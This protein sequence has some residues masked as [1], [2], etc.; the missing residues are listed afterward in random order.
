MV[1]VAQLRLVVASVVALL[2]AAACYQ[3][4]QHWLLLAVALFSQVRASSDQFCSRP[5]AFWADRPDWP[6][7]WSGRAV[8]V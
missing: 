5:A 1:F 8:K 2:L 7:T 6:T 3:T 4:V